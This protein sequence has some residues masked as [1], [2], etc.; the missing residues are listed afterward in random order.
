MPE[1]ISVD[2]MRRQER[3]Q[4]RLRDLEGKV[5]ARKLGEVNEQHVRNLEKQMAEREVQQRDALDAMRGQGAAHRDGRVTPDVPD[6]LNNPDATVEDHIKDLE[7][8]A[9]T[10]EAAD[11]DLFRAARGERDA[12]AHSEPG[13][14][15]MDPGKAADEADAL[16]G[17]VSPTM[18]TDPANKRLDPQV[19]VEPAKAPAS[20]NP[21]G[22]YGAPTT[23]TD[24][25]ATRSGSKAA[26]QHAKQDAAERDAKK[27]D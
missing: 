19:Q 6:H 12:A 13:S 25:N 14:R 17:P 16:H 26:Q 18:P 27:A 8:R 4:Q 1:D 11:E 9:N 5:G 22:A 23:A 2:E 10:A 24:K 21:E 7:R 20:K 3:E 15:P